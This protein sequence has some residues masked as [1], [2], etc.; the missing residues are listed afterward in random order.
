MSLTKRSLVVGGTSGIGRGIA[1][2]LAQQGHSV[3]I[4]GRSEEM[5]AQIVQEL[6]AMTPIGCGASHN[7]QS[8][9]GFS[10]DSVKQLALTQTE[11][12]LDYLV[13]TQ[14]MAT[15]QGYTPTKDGL[16]QKLQLHV[17]SRIVLASLLAPTLA[18]SSEASKAAGGSGDGCAR[19]LSVL[20]AGVHSPYPFYET[21]PMLENNY[22]I[23]NAADAAGTY[24]DIFLDKL[25]AKH[26]DVLFA[27]AA[28]GF[29]NTSWG[30]EMP[31]YVRWVVRALQPLGKSYKTSGR[32]LGAGWLALRND[33]PSPDAGMGGGKVFLMNEN[34]RRAAHMPIHDEIMTSGWWENTQQRLS[35]WL[36]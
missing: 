9:D 32:E 24:N 17:Y 28:P 20:S 31:F 30:T 14:G 13:M 23:K 4:A 33:S 11:K 15:I 12:G 1:E 6:T 8:V 36:Q 16:D 5:G 2:Y 18:K 21:D 19:V 25:A 7:F 22:S 27:H 35:K 10:L 26:T 3:T 29:V 34:G